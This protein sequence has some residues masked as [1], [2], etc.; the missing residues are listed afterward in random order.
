MKVASACLAK[1]DNQCVVQALAGKARTAQEMGLLI[2]TYRAM[3][4]AQ[5][6][7]KYMTLYVKRFRTASRAS[8]YERM[9]EQ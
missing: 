5:A 3:G 7:R 6:A 8:S 2:E 4:N 9:L 1:G